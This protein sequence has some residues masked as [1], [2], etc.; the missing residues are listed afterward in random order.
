M[1]QDVRLPGIVRSED[2]QEMNQAAWAQGSGQHLDHSGMRLN[3][4]P[5]RKKA[6]KQV[7]YRDEDEVKVDRLIKLFQREVNKG[8]IFRELIPYCSFLLFMLVIVMVSRSEQY[9]AGVHRTVEA[10]KSS[11]IDNNYM[12]SSD[13]TFRKTFWDISNEDDFWRWVK[14]PLMTNIWSQGDNTTLVAHANKPLGYLILRQQRV[15]AEPCSTSEGYHAVASAIKTHLP[16]WCYPDY[17]CH[18]GRCT[19]SSAPF[20]GAA[21]VTEPFVSV[22]DWGSSFEFSKLQGQYYT[23]ASSEK[24][25]VSAIPLDGLT[26]Q[27]AWKRADA[28]RGSG[29]VDPA[30]RFLS[31]ELVLLN[32][33]TDTFLYTAAFIEI[34]AGGLWHP[35]LRM[36]PFR[37]LSIDSVMGVAIFI[38]DIIVTIYFFYIFYRLVQTLFRNWRLHGEILSFFG[39]W[40]TY[41]LGNMLLFMVTYGY[42]WHYWHVTLLLRNDRYTAM[43]PGSVQEMWSDL[44]S[45][46]MLYESS[47]NCYGFACALAIGGFFRFTQYNPRLFLL[48]ETVE[49]ALGELISVVAMMSIVLFAYGVLGNILFGYYM[50]EYKSFVASCGTLLRHLIGDFPEEGYYR[51]RDSQNNVYTAVVFVVTYTFIAWCI[52]LN[53]ILAIINESLAAVKTKAGQQDIMIMKWLQKHSN[54]LYNKCVHA[55]HTLQQHEKESEAILKEKTKREKELLTNIYERL[56]EYKYDPQFM[57]KMMKKQLRDKFDWTEEEWSFL[58]MYMAS[59]RH[60]VYER[61]TDTPERELLEVLHCQ[62]EDLT[63]LVEHLVSSAPGGIP[64]PAPAP[65]SQQKD[66][67]QPIISHL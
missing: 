65:A 20:G 6:S 5:Q 54:R 27:D 55:A 16:V 64:D 29:W 28:L 24:S 56:K 43:H 1:G 4:I 49:R 10:V 61:V 48:V 62:V 3:D 41:A 2:E 36:V 26:L 17:V 23:Y 46:G 14:Q 12:V 39:F 60:D 11:I 38:L 31:A 15:A 19:L 47:W 53:M 51:M 22:K 58:Q 13:L 32:R 57:E 33:N 67:G 35:N 30:T 34:S 66:P 42:R 45:Y 44:V 50:L 52:L 7:T 9:E 59:W 63:G 21:A 40:N 8:Y 37:F 25:F 18:I